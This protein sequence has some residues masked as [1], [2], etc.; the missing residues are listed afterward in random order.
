VTK[1]SHALAIGYWMLDN[2]LSLSDRN[3]FFFIKISFIECNE[4]LYMDYKIMLKRS[5]N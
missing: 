5:Y 4:I 1:S 3:I 2:I